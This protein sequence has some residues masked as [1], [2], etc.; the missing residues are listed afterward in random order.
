MGVNAAQTLKSACSKP[1][2]AQI[3]N[4]DMAAIADYNIDHLTL[5]ADD[6]TYLAFDFMGKGR[7]LA[8]RLMGDYFVG[9]Q[10]AVIQPSQSFLLAG[11]QASGLTVYLFDNFNPS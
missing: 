5:A 2:L 8:G 9:R 1:V 11:L 3:G 7:D 4:P 6:Q 10:S